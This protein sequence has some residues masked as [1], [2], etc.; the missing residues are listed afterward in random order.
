MHGYYSRSRSSAP[1]E[2]P[3]ITPGLLKRVWTY[4]RPYRWWIILMLT[5]TLATSGL[6]LLTPL[7]LRDLIDRT[8]PQH[9]LQRL[10]RLI[11]A[12]VMLPLMT[13]GLN[14]VLR[15]LSARV[16][17]G[18]VYDLRVPFFPVCSAC[19]SVSLHTHG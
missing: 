6:G 8:L 3:K 4:A 5:I 17:E 12:L 11:V 18:V 7:I 15:Q 14:V 9:D 19:R 16:G 13:G 1:D 2:K 10:L